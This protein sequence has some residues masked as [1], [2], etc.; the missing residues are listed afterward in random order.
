MPTEAWTILNMLEWATDYFKQKEVP[1][2]RLSTEW[3]LADV[4]GIKRLDLYL[5]FER[6]L[7]SSELDR[8]RPLIK[9]R[10][11]HEPLQYITGYC[12]FL[13][14]RLNVTPDVLIPRM[15]TEQLVEKILNRHSATDVHSVLDIGT[16]SGCIAIALKANRPGWE[17]TAVDHSEKALSVARQNAEQQNTDIH[18]LQ[19]NIHRQLPDQLPSRSF[20]IIVSNPPYILPAQ[21]DS[22]ERQVKDYEPPEALFCRDIKK[23][24]RT[25]AEKAA[26]LLKNKGMLYLEINEEY[27]DAILSVFDPHVW[28]CTLLKDYGQNPRFIA[29]FFRN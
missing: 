11:S 1:S 10:A 17:L 26:N 7:A 27:P 3:L 20:D 9:R 23:Q 24:Y 12:D 19:V 15:E 28:D 22:L 25:I 5:E 29:A 16:G 2:P 13:N 6:P 8:L 18:F 21:K 4:L 14:T